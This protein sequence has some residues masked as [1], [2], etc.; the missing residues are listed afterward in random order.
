DHFDKAVAFAKAAGLYDIHGDN[1]NTSLKSR[2]DYLE[3]YG[4]KDE[5]Q[6]RLFPDRVPHS[7]YFVIEQKN[8][9]GEWELLLSGGLRFLGAY[10][11]RGSGAGPAF[12]RSMT[13]TTGWSIRT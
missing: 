1:R 9:A 2:L 8:R 7:F 12:A 3:R 5:T 13:R 6:V 4:A 11:G 10:D